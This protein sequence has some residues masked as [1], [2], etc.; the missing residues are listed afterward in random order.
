MIYDI[1]KQ[2]KTVTDVKVFFSHLVNNRSVNF[3]PDDDFSQYQTPLGEPA[4]TESEIKQ[5]NKR[6][7]E[8]FEVCEKFDTDIYEL[9]IDALCMFETN[10]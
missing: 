2:I 4:F 9:G 5:Y 7:E 1:K 10:S 8:C 6:M 3:H